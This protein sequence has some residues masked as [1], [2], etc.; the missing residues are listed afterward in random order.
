MAVVPPI[1]VYR[2]FRVDRTRPIRPLSWATDNGRDH[3]VACIIHPY[4]AADRTLRHGPSYTSACSPRAHGES[5]AHLGTNVYR[6]FHYKYPS[7]GAE[8]P[9][10]WI[11]SSNNESYSARTTFRLQTG[12]II[13]KPRR[14]LGRRRGRPWSPLLIF[15]RLPSMT[16]PSPPLL[17]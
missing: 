12:Q 2:A 7:N 8:K 11:H 3:H 10:Q 1:R 14:I 5:Y 16:I 13:I 4:P 15:W 9:A 17:Q 6:P